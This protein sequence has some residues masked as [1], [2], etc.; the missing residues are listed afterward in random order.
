MSDMPNHPPVQAP[1]VSPY[2]PAPVST[3]MAVTALV[4][5]ILGVVM[6]PLF[7]I[8]AIVL[9]IIAILRVGREP[10]RYGGKGMAIAGLSCGGASLLFLPM[11]IAILLPS[12]SR[13]RELSKRLVCASNLKA[14]TTATELYLSDA[15]MT[16][17]PLQLL[18]DEGYLEPRTTTCPAVRDIGSNYVILELAADPAADPRA[19][20]AY[21]PKSNHGD[22]GGNV[23]FADGHVEFIKG[24]RFDDLIGNLPE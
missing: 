5:G 21:E 7:G 6:C 4:L 19:V 16:S 8:V 18:I 11:L 13:A 9:G 2:P 10:H 1:V 15:D 23:V 20:I 12:L 17:I 24:Q 3:G 22:E 14:I